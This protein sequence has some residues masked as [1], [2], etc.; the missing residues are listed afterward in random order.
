M[1]TATS[2]ERMR[3]PTKAW[4]RALERTAAIARE[5]ALTLPLLIDR[6]A[7]RFADAPALMGPDSR[8]SYGALSEASHRFSRWGLAQGLKRGDVICLLMRNCPEYLA[9]WLG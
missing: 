7:E 9:I 8:L 5:P 6:L 4:M 3:S 1:M 2:D